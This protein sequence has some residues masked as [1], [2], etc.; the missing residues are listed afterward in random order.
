MCTMYRAPLNLSVSLFICSTANTI[1]TTTTSSIREVR[2]EWLYVSVVVITRRGCRR[3]RV[4]GNATSVPSL[5]VVVVVSCRHP[6][7]EC[8]SGIVAVVTIRAFGDH[9]SAAAAVACPVVRPSFN[10]SK[11]KDTIRIICL[12]QCVAL[13]YVSSCTP[14]C[15]FLS[16]CVVVVQ[17]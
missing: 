16:L 4:V 13:R 3:V 11:K 14:V 10:D 7:W 17:C 12:L 8:C 15:S 1:T 2:D 9:R 5:L 6:A